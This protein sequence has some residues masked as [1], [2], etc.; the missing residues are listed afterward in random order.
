MSPALRTLAI[1]SNTLFMPSTTTR[2]VRMQPWLHLLLALALL[3]QALASAAVSV[4]GFTHRHD[5]EANQAPP[6][7]LVDF[8]RHHSAIEAQGH[9]HGHA[10]P[11]RHH[12][13]TSAAGIV[14][15][16]DDQAADLGSDAADD[17][18]LAAQP[19]LLSPSPMPVPIGATPPRVPRAAWDATMHASP[20]PE[21]PPRR[22]GTPVPV[23]ADA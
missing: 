9:A 13:G 2:R 16:A 3:L 6:T 12:H 7:S 15:T 23:I 22:E 11:A 20:L 18:G 4:T 14:R 5:T 19:A 1:A 10:Q 21:R 8:R 17:H